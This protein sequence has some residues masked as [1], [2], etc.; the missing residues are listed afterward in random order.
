MEP[1][2]FVVTLIVLAL[3][4][5]LAQRFGAD[6]RADGPSWPGSRLSERGGWREQPHA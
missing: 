2:V 3:V 6:T 5:G 1:V 4:A